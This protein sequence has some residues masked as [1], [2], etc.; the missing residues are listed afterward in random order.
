MPVGWSPVS[1]TDT[2][3]A[4]SATAAA[5]AVD[6][7]KLYGE[8]ETIVRALDGVTVS[9]ERAR[10]TAIMGPSGSGK[11]TLMHCLAGLDRLS[12]GRVFIGDTYLDTLN[13]GTAH[14]AAPGHGRLRLPGVQPDPHA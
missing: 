5:G 6:A 10:Y 11:S 3:S 14:R 1:T 8:G 7:T 4:P 12:D 9:F 2:S 13:D